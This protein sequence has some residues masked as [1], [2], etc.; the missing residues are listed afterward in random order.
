MENKIINLE[1][2]RKVA[3]GL[4]EL[5]EL[6]VFVGGAIVSVYA[7]DEA[8]E[9]VRPTDDIDFT[10]Q[11]SSYVD[12]TKLTEQLQT[13]GFEPDQNGHSICSFLFKGIRIDVIPTS[14]T[15][16]GA[17][18][19]W[20]KIGFEHLKTVKHEECNINIFSLP[21]FIATKF[22]AYNN[23][24]GDYRTSH[25]FEDIIYVIDNSLCFMEEI[26]LAPVEVRNFIIEELSK[27]VRNNNYKEIISSQLHPNSISTRLQLII[28][29]IETI[30]S[31]TY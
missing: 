29:K 24:G 20:Y 30:I 9:E 8:A 5:N 4:E 14:D 23:R 28:D 11:I 10:V 3:L 26:R 13:K 6:A 31:T 22:E 17:T 1:L 21:I 2:V 25:D 19:K 12:F 18:N 16:I 27:V 7:D 15:E